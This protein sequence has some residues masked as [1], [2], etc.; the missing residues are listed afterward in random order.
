MAIEQT[1]RSGDVNAQVGR[2]IHARMEAAGMTQGRLAAALGLTQAAV[3]RKLS[4]ERPWFAAELVDV[5]AAL[6]VSVG[7]LFGELP[8]PAPLSV[9]PARCLELVPA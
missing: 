8:A 7:E 6:K 1:Q 4:G 2:R 5:A 3:S 9:V